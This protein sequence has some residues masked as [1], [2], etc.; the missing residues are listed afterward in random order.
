M[1]PIDAEALATLQARLAKSEA[2]RERLGRALAMAEARL[3]TLTGTCA[4][5]S[6]TERVG[7]WHCTRADCDEEWIDED[8]AKV[9]DSWCASHRARYDAAVKAL[10]DEV[11][12]WKQRALTAEAWLAA[13]SDDR[14]AANEPAVLGAEATWRKP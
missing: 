1:S 14:K 8:A 10:E 4:C 3:S 9:V 6:E 7:P 13:R 2:N 5:G 12:I 11:G